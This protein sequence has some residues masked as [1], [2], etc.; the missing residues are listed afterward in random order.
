VK[1]IH[2]V[3]DTNQWRDLGKTEMKLRVL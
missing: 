3:Q 2:L 1:W